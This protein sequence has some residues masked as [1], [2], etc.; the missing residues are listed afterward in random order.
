VT[1]NFKALP[2]LSPAELEALRQRES[3]M[4]GPVVKA[5]GFTPGN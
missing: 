3:A 5:S 4:W 2:Q 1:M